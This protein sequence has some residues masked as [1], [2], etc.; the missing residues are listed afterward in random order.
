[1]GNWIKRHIFQP[2]CAAMVVEQGAMMSKVWIA[3]AASLALVSCSALGEKEHSTT[4]VY[5]CPSRAGS[6]TP[7]VYLYN[8]LCRRFAGHARLRNAGQCVPGELDGRDA[9]FV[10]IM[11]IGPEHEPGLLGSSGWE[12]VYMRYQASRFGV[13][14][15]R[16][17]NSEVDLTTQ[18]GRQIEESMRAY[19][20]G[21]VSVGQHDYTDL[22]W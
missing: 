19:G 20:C 13:Q 8:D 2:A 9:V 21:S 1:M 7:V 18:I 11:D 17:S 5:D 6:A 4:Y 22:S 14:V 10:L 3:A 12:T 15:E 16:G